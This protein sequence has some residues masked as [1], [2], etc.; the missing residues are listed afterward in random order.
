M[1]L[2]A[3]VIEVLKA[4]PTP[5][6]G[7]GGRGVCWERRRLHSGFLASWLLCVQSR[8]WGGRRVSLPRP[9]CAHGWSGLEPRGSPVGVALGPGCWAEELRVSQSCTARQWQRLACAGA[10]RPHV[11]SSPAVSP[12][13]PRGPLSEDLLRILPP[14]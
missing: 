12:L 6:Q 7:A 5:P 1:T 13:L 10:S 3:L 8:D 9:P 2:P 11:W 4:Q 14:G